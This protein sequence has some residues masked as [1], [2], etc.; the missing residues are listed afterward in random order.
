[1]ATFQAS[2]IFCLM[3]SHNQ[4]R[5]PKGVVIKATANNTPKFHV[6]Q[7]SPPPKLPT[8]SLIQNLENDCFNFPI[9][10]NNTSHSSDDPTV[11]PELYAIMDTIAD[12]V[13]MHKNIGAQRDNWNH[14]LLI[15][16][17]AITLTAATMAGLAAAARAIS[18]AKAPFMALKLS[19]T[20]LYVSAAAMLAVT[21]KIQPSQLAEEQRNAARLFK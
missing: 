7:T 16:I 2:R 5:F 15:S 18:T 21:N 11:I 3:D 9:N 13:E 17:N 4:I 14:L 19:S 20:L 10:T 6:S 1:M 12:R 8:R